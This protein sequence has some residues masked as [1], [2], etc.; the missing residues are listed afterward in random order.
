[1]SQNSSAVASQIRERAKQLGFSDAQF[2]SARAA[3]DDE[4]RLRE[5]FV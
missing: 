3:P 2:T 1:M 4:I 5:F